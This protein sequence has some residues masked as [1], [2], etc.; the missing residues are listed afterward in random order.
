MKE[1]LVIYYLLVTKHS[2]CTPD[3]F[4]NA[5]PCYIQERL[6]LEVNYDKLESSALWRVSV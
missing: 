1:C 5:S 2:K 6:G 4:S 3:R